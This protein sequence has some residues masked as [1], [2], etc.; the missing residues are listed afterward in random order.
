[1]T[2]A[3]V[4]RLLAACLHQAILETM[5]PRLEFYETWLHGEGLREGSIGRAPMTAVLG[6]L[7]T[8][9][10]EYDRVVTRAGR[11]AAEWTLATLPPL[12]RRFVS[13]MPRP[14]RA[15]AALRVARGIIRD[16]SSGTRATTRVRRQTA[17]V[18][19]A[20]SLFCAV[21]ERSATP[22]CGFYVAVLAETL[23]RLGV[24]AQGR[25]ERCHAVDAGSCVITLELFSAGMAAPAMAA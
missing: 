18:D 13:S 6:F 23:T 5:P 15:R 9:G 14:L 25:V 2:E 12:Q 20:D 3:R 1:M 10:P 4:G 24:P 16:I 8:E 17:R 22:L 7:R 11:L 21:R 19:V